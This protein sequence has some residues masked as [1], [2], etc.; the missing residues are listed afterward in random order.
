MYKYWKYWSIVLYCATMHCIYF[1]AQYSIFDSPAVS[2][3]YTRPYA[4]VIDRWFVP[5]ASMAAGQTY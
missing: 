2:F 3:S 1:V 4:R 5:E